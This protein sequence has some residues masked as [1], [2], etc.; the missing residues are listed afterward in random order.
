MSHTGLL[1]Q[2]AQQDV[3]RDHEIQGGLLDAIGRQVISPEV[4]EY[5]L[6]YADAQPEQPCGLLELIAQKGVGK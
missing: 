5:G 2:V 6:S 3:P 4:T 1:Q